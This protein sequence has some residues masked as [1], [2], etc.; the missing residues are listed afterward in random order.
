MWIPQAPNWV[1]SLRGLRASPAANP[2][3]TGMDFSGPLAYPSSLS[4][5]PLGSHLDLDGREGI[6]GIEFV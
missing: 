2:C 4:E 3:D 6:V 1:Q 5:V